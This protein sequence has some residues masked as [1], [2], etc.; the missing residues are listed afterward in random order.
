MSN[1]ECVAEQFSGLGAWIEMNEPTIIIIV[2][3]F[4]FIIGEVIAKIRKKK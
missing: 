2:F 4:G 1:L 3:A